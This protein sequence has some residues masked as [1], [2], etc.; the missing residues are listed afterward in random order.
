MEVIRIGTRGSKLA[1][2]Q[3]E[4]VRARLSEARPE[5]RFDIEV[6]RTRG[7]V[8]HD[9]SPEAFGRE[10]IFTAELDRALLDKKIDMAVHSLKDLPTALAR[11]LCVAAVTERASTDDL[12]ILGKDRAE[13]LGISREGAL[14]E[15]L[16]GMERPL[17]TGTSSLRRIALLKN[18]FPAFEFAP[19][20]GN[21]DTRIRKLGEG[22]YDA[23]VVARAGLE[24]LGIETEGHAV[25]PLQPDWYLC[26]AGQGALAVE[27]ETEGRGREI[28]ALLEHTPTRAAVTAERVAM[29]AL[30][31]GCRV[32]AG[33][34]GK[35][36]GDALILKGV[37]GHPSGNPVIRVE[38]EGPASD[39][40][41]VG[42]RMSE[43]LLEMGA[44]QILKEVRG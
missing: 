30:G 10:G 29:S 20:R 40:E 26:A 31:A 9:L 22:E 8:R 28:A 4:W 43:R 27:T 15:A 2:W 11:G 14:P 13:V 44:R 21:L 16:D 42:K 39:P 7:D 1:L 25:I 12:L 36:S 3:S 38:V 19:M 18:R 33:F 6:I 5:L 24:R 35:V 23:I 17:K 37:V 34:L 41:G 32:P